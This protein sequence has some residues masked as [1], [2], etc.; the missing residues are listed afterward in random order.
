VI[1]TSP[2]KDMDELHDRMPVV[3]A[4]ADVEPWLDVQAHDP[5]ER[6]QLLRP[7]PTGTLLHHGVDKAVGSVRNDG[8]QL[9]EPAEPQSFF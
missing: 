8:P 6:M 2:S 1:T 7:A 9:I 4:L 5:D 3:L